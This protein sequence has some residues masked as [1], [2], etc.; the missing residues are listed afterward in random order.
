MTTTT[1]RCLITGATGF[2]GSHLVRRLLAEGWQV[3]AL[4]R[5]QS[6]LQRIEEIVDAVQ[7]H[8]IDEQDD[9]SA[10]LA[11]VDS[12]DAI[13][14]LATA[15]GRGGQPASEVAETNLLLPLR[16][17]E[18]AIDAGVGLFVATDTCFPVDYP[19]L[20]SYTLSKRQFAEWGQVLSDSGR[21]KVV[22]LVLQ[23]PYGPHDTEGKFV[24]WLID[25][26]RRQV[27]E[28]ALTSGEQEKDFVYVGDVVRAYGVLAENIERLPTG[29]SEIECG[30]GQA[31]PVRDFVRMVHRL[32]GSASS[33]NFGALADRTGEVRRSVADTTAL[34]ALGWRPEVVLEQ[35]LRHTI[36]ADEPA[37]ASTRVAR[38]A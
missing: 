26:C 16:L 5:S 17:L 22:D 9:I 13:F 1:K 19:Y 14:H 28:I 12:V 8:R 23:H 11:A 2:I 10:T 34:C 18:W 20:R 29:F 3:H 31:T 30:S 6:S 33:L 15:Y 38:D 24:P 7:L 37:S 27:P 25:Q 4:V 35:G 21:T 36:A 32:S